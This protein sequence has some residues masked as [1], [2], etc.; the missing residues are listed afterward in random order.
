MVDYHGVIPT[1]GGNQ[2]TTHNPIN[3]IRYKIVQSRH[4]I[5]AQYGWMSDYFF[6]VGRIICPIL[7]LLR[8]KSIM[9][10]DMNSILMPAISK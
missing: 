3:Y 6:F 10:I 8:G 7:H 9:S 1:K 4:Q 5:S 2:F